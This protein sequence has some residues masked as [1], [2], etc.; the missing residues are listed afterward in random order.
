MEI[1]LD[2]AP[3]PIP[4]SDA[5]AAAAAGK[6]T[7][8]MQQ[9]FEI[10]SQHPECILF[11]RMGDFYELFHD[12]AEITHRVLGITL[13]QRSEGVPMA[14]IPYHA[15][16]GY[17][18]TM[19][20]EGWRCAVVDQLE[21]P[22][23][24][25]G[26]VKRGV[27]RILTP[28]T[29]TDEALLDAGRDNLLG[30][31]SGAYLAV[32]DVSTG[33]FELHPCASEETPAVA[34]RLSIQ[35]L[36]LPI[37]PDED[38]DVAGLRLVGIH[39]GTVPA[40]TCGVDEARRLL[41]RQFGITDL[42][43]FGLTEDAAIAAAGGLLRAIQ[44][45]QDPEAAGDRSTKLGHLQ[46]PQI[47]T[48]HGRL[49]LDAVA[50]SAL[51]IE[52]TNRAGSAEGSL[53]STFERP[54]SPMGRR[55]L[56]DRCCRPY[57]NLSEINA[58][59]DR[60]AALLEPAFDL[61]SLRKQMGNI[62]DLPRIAARAG[63]GRATPRDLAALGN[64]L[65]AASSLTLPQQGFVEISKALAEES[66]QLEALREQFSESFV[67]EPPQHLREG[68]LFR[69]GV[70]AELDEART[71]ERD[72]G[73]W[74]TQYQQELSEQY[75]IPSLRVMFNRVFGY[76]IEVT[77]TH[78]EK[79]PSHWV[80][81]QTL[82]NSERYI[83]EELKAWEEKVLTAGERA[84]KR[85]QELF[86][87][88]ILQVNAVAN[89]LNAAAAL[90]AEIDVDT[91]FA[92][93]ARRDGSI[94]PNMIESPECDLVGARHPVLD[95]LLGAEFVPLD[96]K[97]GG[98]E[99]GL[100]LV[101]GPNMAGKSTAIRTAAL[102]TLLAHAG[103][104]VPAASATIGR[105]D[106]ILTRIGASDELHA[107][108]S[109]FMVEMTETASILH[110]ATPHSLVVLDEIGRGTSTL[111]GLALAWSIAEHLADLGARTLFATHYHELTDLADTR[112]GVKN[113]HVLV[114]EWGE[115]IVF[116]HRL[117]AG[118]AGR[119]WGVQVARLAGMPATTISRAKEL[120]ERLAVRVE[121]TGIDHEPTL[122]D[123]TPVESAPEEHPIVQKIRHADL[124][125]LSPREAFE[126]LTKWQDELGPDPQADG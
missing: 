15:L 103:A 97:L 23:E 86:D 55:A 76:G 47:I 65:Q 83:T 14:G 52:R 63:L 56:R 45:T 64:T 87:Q 88:C 61:A 95:R 96:V 28:G 92:A 13:T 74:L 17:L 117:E 1:T 7:P 78:R 53:L 35:E 8:A 58:A 42:A 113:L 46:P 24:A 107:G 80:R 122:F 99:P 75:D 41:E 57:G 105:C 106:R 69:D 31:H 4:V 71:L 84:I 2:P 77:N 121:G 118:R 22:K 102:L 70:D 27:T 81:K 44:N 104:Y 38:P 30:L 124:D 6:Q 101:T 93:T 91:T 62:S 115:G 110:A 90:I 54:R 29:V 5:Q 21:N 12:D 119:S 120:L 66:Q 43:G 48:S 111:D 108:R 51:E 18:A 125:G 37:A 82:R 126:L 40:W 39:P 3:G 100:A 112:S 109:T 20:E 32:A 85:E 59:H 94:R 10:K 50:L 33:R 25:K 16:E 114:R 123:Q 60:V 72:A 89:H 36:L 79:V 98:S 116:L 73:A 26:V 49:R 11:F 34:R 19:L 9:W 68:G 67:D